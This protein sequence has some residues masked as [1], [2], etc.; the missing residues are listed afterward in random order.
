MF[1]FKTQ[2]GKCPFGHGIELS[3]PAKI[4]T[5]DWSFG[6]T[7]QAFNYIKCKCGMYFL[8]NA[9]IP[10]EISWAYPDNDYSG[11]KKRSSLVEIIRKF[12]YQ[13]N[14]KF[15]GVGEEKRVLD[16][17]CGNG[18]LA[19]ALA[20]RGINVTAFDFTPNSYHEQLFKIDMNNQSLRFTSN[21]EDL[22]G[23]FDVIFML[24]VIE[25]LYDPIETLR[26]LKDKLKPNGVI[27]I[28]TPTKDGWDSMIPPH[29]MWGGWHAPRHLHIWNPQQLRTLSTN[30]NLEVI[31]FKYIPSPFL[32]AETIRYRFQSR[33]MHKLLDSDN[34]I[35]ILASVLL[36][37]VQI[38]IR[39]KT[40][41]FRIV[42]RKKTP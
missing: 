9:P 38:F 3:Q 14:L 20:E 29:E 31:E 12:S 32:W 17:G 36:D 22:G 19:T 10:E 33:F 1:R 15:V 2:A 24:Q 18:E 21:L 7:D 23:F 8:E 40:S 13:K 5:K 11:W 34:A 28:E 25:H 26:N 4:S 30:L 41:N 16:F 35:F 27:I 37:F 39:K 42:M 6:T